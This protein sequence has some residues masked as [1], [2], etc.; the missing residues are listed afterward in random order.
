MS[1]HWFFQFAVVRVTPNMFVSL[2]IYGAY[3]FWALVCFLGFVLLGLWAPE[4]KG[5][6]MERMEELFAGKWWMGWNA[7]VQDLHDDGANGV[8]A[9]EK[10][11]LSTSEV[12]KV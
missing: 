10:D 11:R 7:K 2:H 1:L 8:K 12:E 3:I 4:T 9:V 6:P 5:I